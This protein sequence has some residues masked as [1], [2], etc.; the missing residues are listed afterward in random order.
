MLCIWWTY[1]RAC[2]IDPGPRGW[3]NRVVLGKPR[4]VEKE[5]IK[6]DK[7]NG[8][9][10][11][12]SEEEEEGEVVIPKG[13]RWCKKCKTVKPPRA[14]HCRKCA[15]YFPP[16]PSLPHL[17]PSQMYPKNGPPLPLDLKLR[18]PHHISPLPPL[19][20]LL[21]HHHVPPRIP[22][23]HT[24]LT[25]LVPAIPPFISGSINMGPLP[26]PRPRHTE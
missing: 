12:S 8:S 11:D 17:I 25:H 19:R 3:V 21:P 22:P 18:I 16:S 23:L 20:L 4:E 13:M 1:D 24:R 5:D 26:P 10:I 7:K 2:T 6:T 15:R 9:E 14:H